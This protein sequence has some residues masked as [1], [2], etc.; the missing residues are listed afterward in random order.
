MACSILIPTYNRSQFDALISE[1]ITKQRY[2]FI[3]EVLIADDGIE[4]LNITCPYPIRYFTVPRCSIGT[5]R[6]FLIAQSSTTSEYCAFFDTDD[7]YSQH[8]ISKSIFNLIQSGKSISGSSDMIMR[9]NGVLYKS[10]CMYRDMLN[11]AT[12]VFKRSHPG[13]FADA[14]SGEGVSFLRD[15]IKDIVET[16]IESLMICNVHEGNT[17]PKDNWI[18]EKYRIKD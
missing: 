10:R 4:L 9:K 18:E 11:E 15:Y 7:E 3:S 2:P 6:N 8:F 14:S 17:V 1:N 13:K 12:L 5:K 16:D